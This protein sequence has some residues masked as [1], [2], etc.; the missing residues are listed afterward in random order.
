VLTTRPVGQFFFE[1]SHIRTL[2][3][4]QMCEND[5]I[6]SKSGV[7]SAKEEKLEENIIFSSEQT[8]TFLENISQVKAKLSTVT[9]VALHTRIAD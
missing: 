7:K 4:E 1:C 6:C 2:I 5:I 3:F 9:T 8:L